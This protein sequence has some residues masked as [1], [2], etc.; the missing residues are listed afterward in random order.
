MGQPKLS[1][2]VLK[3]S[4]RYPAGVLGNPKPIAQ[5]FAHT[6][7]LRQSALRPTEPPR[8]SPSEESRAAAHEA[9]APAGGPSGRTRWLHAGLILAA[10]V[11]SLILAVLWLGLVS[12]PRST[13]TVPLPQ[14][15]TASPSAVLTAPARIEAIAGEDVSFPIALDGTDGVPSRSVIAVTGLPQ[16]SNFSEGRPYGDSEWS[17]K[18]DQIGDLDLVLPAGANGEFKLGIALIGPDDAVIAEAETLLEITPAPPAPA[19]AEERR[20][21]SPLGNDTAASAPVPDDSEAAAPTRVTDGAPGGEAGLEQK[22]ATV[23]AANP[24]AGEPATVGPS[25]DAESGLGS[26]Q[27]S[28]YVNLR[29]GPSSSAPV[30]GVIAKGAKLSVLDRKRGWVQVAD[31]ATDKKGWIYSGNLVGEAKAHHSRG[32]RAAPAETAPASESFWG[33]IGSWLSPS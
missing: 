15:R 12:M 5:R 7:D 1:P 31:P 4:A 9:T 14:V 30:V 19:S 33:R 11:P 13:P 23:E 16:G 17:L 27:P 24:A 8:A 26:V 2:D 10:L 29:E 25:K 21:P 32:K 18:P 22:P 6:A 28:V 3:L 20:V